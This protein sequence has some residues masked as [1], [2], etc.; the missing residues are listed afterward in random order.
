MSITASLAIYFL[1]WV[2]SAFLVMP[3]GIRTHDDVGAETIPGQVTSA[4]VNFNAKLIAK[5]ATW[6]SLALFVLYYLNYVQ[7]WVT[8]EDLDVSRLFL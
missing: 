4:P 7:G 1:L 8:I 6:L 5:R 2:L 3:F